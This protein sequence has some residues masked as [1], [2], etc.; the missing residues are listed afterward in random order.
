VATK[1]VA[2]YFRCSTRSAAALCSKWVDAGFLVVENPSRKARSY[3][4]ADIYE[5]LVAQQAGE[6]SHPMKAP[7]Q[8]RR[9]KR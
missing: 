8:T 3:R 2:M 5:S 9:R 4:L 1:D 7:P 6:V